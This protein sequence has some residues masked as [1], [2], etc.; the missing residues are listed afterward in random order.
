MRWCDHKNR[1]Q[2]IEAIRLIN[3]WKIE[4][5]NIAITRTTVQLALSPEQM[6]KRNHHQ[7]HAAASREET[8][9]FPDQQPTKQSFIYRQI[10]GELKRMEFLLCGRKWKMIA[11][12]STR[13][14]CSDVQSTNA[15]VRDDNALLGNDKRKWFPR[16]G[17]R[18]RKNI[19]FRW[20]REKPI[21]NT[22]SS[23]TLVALRAEIRKY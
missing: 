20:N 18:W 23:E 12:K 17:A 16:E 5:R 22:C 7:Q 4:M 9:F 21:G 10:L 3:L 11:A 8:P 13:T 14:S 19:S 6:V 1:I 15:K 2:P